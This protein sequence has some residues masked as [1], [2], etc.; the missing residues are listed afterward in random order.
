MGLLGALLGAVLAALRSRAG[1]RDRR[2][3]ERDEIADSIGVPVLA[4]ISVEHPSNAA[5]WRKL[6][7][8]YQPGAVD[9][10]RMRKALQYL[11]L[12]DLSPTVAKPAA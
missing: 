12:T 9:A 10:W 6:L 5:G 11:G 2:L 8:E 3:R 4:S 7:E 1:R